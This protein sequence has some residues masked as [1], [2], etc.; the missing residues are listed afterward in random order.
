[1]PGDQTRVSKR[2]ANRTPST[3]VAQLLEVGRNDL[4]AHVATATVLFTSCAFREALSF[5]LAP[6]A[7][8]AIFSKNTT[9]SLQRAG[10]K[11]NIFQNHFILYLVD[12]GLLFLPS[13][14]HGVKPLHCLLVSGLTGSHD[15]FKNR[16]KD[17]H[18]RGYCCATR[19]T[20]SQKSEGGI[21]LMVFRAIS[22]SK[23]YETP[24]CKSSGREP[25]KRCNSLRR[26]QV[27]HTAQPPILRT[28]LHCIELFSDSLSLRLWRWALSR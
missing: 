24:R 15:G 2:H 17:R 12:T 26:A 1:M 7:T 21:N 9:A 13:L 28:C 25:C 4:S 6:H 18:A 19:R 5:F 3:T 16:V 20:R 27:L 11:T 22:P 8:P 10:S 23:Y 14:L